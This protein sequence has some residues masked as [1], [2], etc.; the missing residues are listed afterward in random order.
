MIRENTTDLDFTTSGENPLGFFPFGAMSDV[1]VGP[2]GSLY[3][4]E[5]GTNRVLR[6]RAPQNG[7]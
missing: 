4:S 1:A 6:F 7:R 5:D 2:D 3:V